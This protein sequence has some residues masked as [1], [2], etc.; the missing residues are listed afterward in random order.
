[1]AVA[2]VLALPPQ[3]ATASCKFQFFFWGGFNMRRF[4]CTQCLS[5]ETSL[6]IS[7]FTSQVLIRCKDCQNSEAIFYGDNDSEC[8]WF[9]GRVIRARSPK[10][11]YACKRVRRKVPKLRFVQYDENQS[12]RRNVLV[13]LS[14]VRNG[15]VIAPGRMQLEIPF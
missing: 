11:R 15:V 4:R 2:R 12:S 10:A 9:L 13:F 14:E 1:M 5:L 6:G 8:Q 3:R 7:A